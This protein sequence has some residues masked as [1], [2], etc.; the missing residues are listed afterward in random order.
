MGRS[1]ALALTIVTYAAFTGL[2]AVAQTWC[3]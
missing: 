3:S 2:S 1:R